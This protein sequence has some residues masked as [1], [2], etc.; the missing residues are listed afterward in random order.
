[1]SFSAADRDFMTR[2]LRLAERGLYSATPNPR[3]GCVIVKEG[4]CIAE[5][6][7]RRA[8]APHAEV[9]A[10]EAAGDAR[11]ATVYVTLEPCC[12]YGRTPPCTDALIAAGVSRVVAALQDPNPKVAGQG[13]SVLRAAGIAVDCG[14]LE[15]EA[16]DLN[17]GFIMRMT[18]ARPW[19]RIKAAASLDGKTA[20]SGGESQW[21]TG[22]DARRDGHHWR[23][24]A[25]AILSGIGTALKDDP[26][27]NV[28]EVET[29]RQPLKI[30]VDSR[31]RLPLD[32]RALEEGNFLIAAAVESAETRR[33][34]DALRERGA[35]LLFLPNPGGQVDLMALMRELGRRQINEVHVEAGARLNGAL[36]EAGVADEL[37]LYLAPCLIGDSARGL[38]SLTELETLDGRKRLDIRDIR[39]IGGDI[40]VRGFFKRS[41]GASACRP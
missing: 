28:R 19:V 22:E 30:I 23:A 29:P 21:I 24:R 33:K 35:E 6:W 8:G 14:L 5:G 4:R 34:A 25:C 40:C 36:L 12:H 7:H 20:L 17:A 15:N 41:N 2:A 27:L 39:R 10:L 9:E 26:R 32:A 16:R 1:M 3:V 18:H 37:L 31:L 11:G 38:F 13:L